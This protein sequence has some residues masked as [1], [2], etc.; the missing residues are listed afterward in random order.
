MQLSHVLRTGVRINVVLTAALCLFAQEPATQNKD[1]KPKETLGLPP[2]VAPTDYQA[3]AKAGEVT[4]AADFV[5]HSVP[6]EQKT[7]STEEFIVVETALFGPPET[8]AHI[9]IDDFSLLING[10]KSLRS[11]PFGLVLSSLKDPEWVPPDAPPAKSKSSFGS[12]GQGE[13]S[14]PP[15]PVKV[16]IELQRA[17][18]QQ[19]QKASLPLGDRVLPQAGLLFFQYRGKAEN[20]NS[21]ELIYSGSVGKASLTLEP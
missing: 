21:L 3:Q 13:S 6:T 18:A 11:Q 19:T 20:I 14:G 1:A 16:P 12:G 10:K 4:I 8:R 9:S 5:R 17:M 7:L 15:P 2:R